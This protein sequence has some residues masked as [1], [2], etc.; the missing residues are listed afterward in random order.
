[1]AT[2]AASSGSRSGTSAVGNGGTA[3][4]DHAKRDVVI[5]AF[6]RKSGLAKRTAEDLERGILKVSCPNGQPL[7]KDA[8]KEYTRQ[9]K[10]L[11]TH[12]RQNGTIAERLS[13]GELKAEDIAAMSDAALTA[14]SQLKKQEEIR[15]ENLHDATAVKPEATAHWTPSDS[16]SCPK[17]ESVKCI[18]IQTFKGSHSYDD[19][20]I[21]PCI[22][23]RCTDCIFL[24]KEDEVEGGARQS[25]GSSAEDNRLVP[26]SRTEG[27]AAVAGKIAAELPGVT[28]VLWGRTGDNWMLTE[29]PG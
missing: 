17:C 11:C 4:A 19:N 12:L 28:P 25:A 18:Y 23:I 26:G 20:N 7:A 10:R 6:Q 21:E 3:G 2:P 27:S 14:E 13:S 24:W 9:Y 16:Y 29:A 8:Y 1:M 22:T 5:Q 15:Q